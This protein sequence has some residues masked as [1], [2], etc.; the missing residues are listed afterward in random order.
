MTSNNKDHV[1][2]KG[3]RWYKDLPR[4]EGK[5]DP[6]PGVSAIVAMHPK[7]ALANFQAKRAAKYAVEHW[8]EIN[9]LLSKKDKRKAYDL[10][11]G[12]GNRYA[13]KA[14][15]D[16]TRIH[17]HVERVLIAI[18]NGEKPKFNVP[19]GDMAYLKSFVRF[20]KEY[21]VQ[22][23]LLEVKVWSE[24]YRY[25]GRLDSL[26]WLTLDGVRVLVDVDTKSG[27]SGV[28]S[29]AALQ[30]V[31]YINADYYVDAEGER[32]DF[33]EVWLATALWLR[34]EGYALIP[35][36]TGAET[37]EH[38][39]RL[40]QSYDWAR[41]CEPNVVGKALNVNPIVRKWKRDI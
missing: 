24:E 33:P 30:Q 19:Q 34:P 9:E 27:A 23:E 39:L 5:T 10:I 37:W 1:K 32:Q 41:E 35:L 22:P 16:G 15:E 8:Q 11:R 21:D 17:K 18:R 20:V 14:A 12:A 4:P 28:W 29:S 2:V 40:R 38:F 7:E 25:A 26:L 13:N 36:D 3:D 6:L 31:A